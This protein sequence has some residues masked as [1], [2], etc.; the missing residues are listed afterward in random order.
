MLAALVLPGPPTEGEATPDA[1]A[2]QIF[3]E[4]LVD[5]VD[6]A[7]A[8][9]VRAPLL[10]RPRARRAPGQDSRTR[11]GSTYLIASSFAANL[12]ISMTAHWSSTVA[13]GIVSSAAAN[14]VKA[15]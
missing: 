1:V 9:S 12:R 13:P 5:P 10:L 4:R 14:A 11:A 2:A 6:R 7:A 8:G 3:H 15:A